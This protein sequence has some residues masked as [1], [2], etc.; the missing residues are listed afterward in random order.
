MPTADNRCRPTLPRPPDRFLPGVN[1]AN[2]NP[3]PQ[4]VPAASLLP[5]FIPLSNIIEGWPETGELLPNQ[6]FIRQ[7]SSDGTTVS[8]WRFLLHTADGSHESARGLSFYDNFGNIFSFYLVG[9]NIEI[10]LNASPPVLPGGTPLAPLSLDILCVFVRKPAPVLVPGPVPGGSVPVSGGPM[11]VMLPMARPMGLM[12][13]AAPPS[14]PKT[15]VLT[16]PVLMAPT[17]PDSPT[18]STIPL[19]D[20]CSLVGVSTSKGISGKDALIAIIG[21]T[22]LQILES[23]AT[24]ED[25]IILYPVDLT[26]PNASVVTCN[27]DP[28]NMIVT[29]AEIKLLPPPGASVTLKRLGTGTVF[30]TGVRITLSWDQDLNITGYL[31]LLTGKLETEYKVENASRASDLKTFLSQLNIPLT[32]GVGSLLSFLFGSEDRAVGKLSRIPAAI[33]LRDLL[34]QPPN[35]QKSWIKTAKNLKGNLVTSKA[36]LYFNLPNKSLTLAALSISLDELYFTLTDPKAAYAQLSLNASASLSKPSGGSIL[37]LSI[38]I[39]LDDDKT[40]T[41]CILSPGTSLSD[42]ESAISSGGK[43]AAE[44]VPF[45]NAPL[46]PAK[47]SQVG[48]ILTQPVAASSS[49]TLSSVFVATTFDD[50]KTFLPPSVLSILPSDLS[51]SI[52]VEVLNPLESKLRATKAAIDF[53]FSI[54]TRRGSKKLKTAFVAQPLVLR[55]DYEYRLRFAIGDATDPASISDVLS[56]VGLGS[57]VDTISTTFP[58]VGT[59]LDSFSINEIAATVVK[60]STSGFEFQDLL[61]DISISSWT[62]LSDVLVLENVNF[63]AESGNGV[64]AGY[65][66]G[67]LRFGNNFRVFV[68]LTMPVGLAP[69]ECYCSQGKT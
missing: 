61:L 34:Q 16:G 23:H 60:S 48:F 24:V 5:A 58:A 33:L 32:I 29:A 4:L 42:L 69:G 46:D 27:R 53:S 44:S 55:G 11:G 68:S 8:R 19:S 30:V 6:I 62:I 10:H 51:A 43:V 41:R 9:A 66:M 57:S 25:E 1:S 38:T 2:P 28:M 17:I 26:T 52:A 37:S 45:R 31:K 56:C 21:T 67:T 3:L 54:Q 47:T 40:S 50:W 39:S 49:T 64:W 35:L 20:Y 63:H 22:N 7:T 65:A 12:M 15:T 13:A 59:V 36:V 18:F 14:K